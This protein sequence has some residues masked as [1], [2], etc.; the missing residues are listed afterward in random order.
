MLALDSSIGC[1][2]ASEADVL[3]LY[4]STP[5]MMA[6]RS[7]SRQEQCEAYVCSIR[8][9]RGIQVYLALV[10]NNRRIFVY[11]SSSG[12]PETE[13]EYHHTLEEALEFARSLGF[14]PRPEN[15]N[16]SPAL[17]EVVVRNFK[18]LRAPGSKVQA[19]LRNG[20]A[21]A[22]PPVPGPKQDS[23]GKVTAPASSVVSA[24]PS[25][26][27]SAAPTAPTA[28]V[29]AK[30]A[31]PNAAVSAGP[32]IAG[33]G[34]SKGAASCDTVVASPASTADLVQAAVGA[35]AA[36]GAGPALAVLPSLAR[37]SLSN[38]VDEELARA[39]EQSQAREQAARDLAAQLQDRL[40]QLE[41]SLDER[42]ERSARHEALQC[43]WEQSRLLLES[44]LTELK[45]ALVQRETALA[46]SSAQSA[47][48]LTQETVARMALDAE[49]VQLRQRFED[50]TGELEASRQELC[51][52][53]TQKEEF[54]GRL[55]TLA[56]ELTAAREE[57]SSLLA[58]QDALVEQLAAVRA[59]APDLAALQAALA[60]LE[61]ES[62]GAVQLRQ[63][64]LRLKDE[65]AAARAGHKEEL[66]QT[67]ARAAALESEVE[68]AREQA[69][70]LAAEM[71][72]SEPLAQAVRQ[73]LEAAYLD[74]DRARTTFEALQSEHAKLAA[75][76]ASAQAELAAAAEGLARQSIA[77]PP[78]SAS[79]N[80][81][82]L[83]EQQLAV[84]DA[85]S[86]VHE[87][88][89]TETGQ[90]APPAV[91]P[92]CVGDSSAFV[93]TDDL[94]S[95]DHAA[96]THTPTAR[97][98]SVA[99]DWYRQPESNAGTSLS[100]SSAD[101]D[102][103]PSDDGAADGPGCFTLCPELAVITC[104]APEQLVQLHTS[105][106]VA[107]LSPDGKGPDSCQGYICC[108]QDEPGFRIFI[109][110]FAPKSSRTWVYAPQF[111]P[112]DSDARAK[113]TAAAVEFAEGVGLM[114]EDIHLGTGCRELVA[115][116]PVLRC[117]QDG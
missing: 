111:Q 85:F 46:E 78:R 37:P 20:T 24:P 64:A 33:S 38:H 42:D 19:L 117:D 81:E 72:Q 39:L 17:R 28:P 107:Y 58:G 69:G 6:L 105:S 29:T 99:A 52:V 21:D 22:A 47:A 48:R 15:L 68:A 116:C 61:A 44:S 51:V 35:V 7:G 101:D 36:A 89:S 109:G 1:I 31:T 54:A 112:Q 10:A 60:S 49:L 115:R 97:T 110:L 55:A 62:A 92:A 30:P 90:N 23:P 87:P 98:T 18:I 14:M 70:R 12:A 13:S 86:P 93:W 50:L 59:E 75:E 103:F 57:R 74:R 67:L 76:L 11:T 114:M 16:Y 40:D 94:S 96:P 27:R 106:N 63:E 8:K 83:K 41:Q 3:D 9:K 2:E 43:E 65:L 32:S 108:L 34:A 80:P 73:E 71:K 84:E 4:S 102:F 26:S 88:N 45:G 53:R 79:L 113:A 56:G 66:A 100:F 77:A 95:L 5:V 82:M 25:A 91:E 104:S